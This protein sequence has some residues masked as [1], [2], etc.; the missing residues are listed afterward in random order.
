MNGVV[1]K[2]MHLIYT[3]TLRCIRM[4]TVCRLKF[5]VGKEFRKCVMNIFIDA[6][7]AFGCSALDHLN[8]I[9]VCSGLI[10]KSTF[11]SIWPFFIKLISSEYYL[12]YI[13]NL[14]KST[15]RYQIFTLLILANVTIYVWQKSLV[16]RY[17][18]CQN[19]YFFEGDDFASLPFC[20][21]TEAYIVHAKR[22]GVKVVRLWILMF[23]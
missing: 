21:L 5:Y 18:I 11:S 1:Q 9:K 15:R 4:I 22:S 8:Y 14:E 17:F 16:R 10:T 6:H 23:S 3:Y 12:Q 7:S 19:N 2:I 20:F 13:A